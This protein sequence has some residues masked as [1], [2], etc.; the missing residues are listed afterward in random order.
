MNIIEVLERAKSYP[1]RVFAVLHDGETVT[2]GD[3]LSCVDKLS[4]IFDGLGLKEGDKIVLSTNDKRS[5]AEITIAAYRYGLTVIL[6]DPNAK[7]DRM[8]SIIDSAK[9]D[10][11]FIDSALKEE[12]RIPDLNCIVIKKANEG[13]KTL[14]K[15]I[16]SQAS[17]SKQDHEAQ[18]HQ[19]SCM[20]QRSDGCDTQIP[21]NTG[22]SLCCLYDVHIRI[23][24]RS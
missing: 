2:Y 11:F 5:V 9:P 12:W 6:S 21:K 10:A 8:H 23:H 19:L 16:F 7:A 15:K 24:I 17:P 4:L 18:D 22:S 14:F 13:K 3:L 20:S 1:K